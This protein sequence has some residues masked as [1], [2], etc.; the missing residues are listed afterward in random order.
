MQEKQNPNSALTYGQ[1]FKIWLLADVILAGLFLLICIG[2]YFIKENYETITGGIFM[3]L[4]AVL[5]EILATLPSLIILFIANTLFRKRKDITNLNTAFQALIIII[6]FLY[7]I[8][9]LP[10]VDYHW[11]GMLLYFISTFAGILSL[12]IITRNKKS[13]KEFSL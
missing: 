2:Y 5:L 4:Y 3:Y 13:T 8:I 1:V 12:H 10:F 11:A 6:N 9:T 7:A